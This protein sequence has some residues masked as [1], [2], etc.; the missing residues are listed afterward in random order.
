MF[1]EE[2]EIEDE[3]ITKLDDFGR[4]N[5]N[6]LNPHI[7]SVESMK[8][9]KKMDIP[10]PSVEDRFRMIIVGG[11]L[12]SAVLASVTGSSRSIIKG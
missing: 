4:V 2:I 7:D 5:I 10:H 11:G 9:I 12:D 8:T 3:L 1:Y 6:F